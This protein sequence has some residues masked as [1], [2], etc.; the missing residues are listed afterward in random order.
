MF[1]VPFGTREKTERRRFPYVNVGIVLVCIGV[2]IWQ[3]YVAATGGE[4]AL[5]SFITTF[6]A[7]PQT[8]TDGTPLEVGLFTSMF[9]H[10]SIVHLLGNMIYLLP[11]GDNVE[12]RLGHVRYLLF[13]ILCGLVATLGFVLLNPHS[14][15]PLLGASGAIAGVLGGYIVS[16]PGA[17][18]RGI[19]FLIII[20]FRVDLPALIFIGYWFFMQLFSTLASYG[21]NPTE[22]GGVAFAA[23]VVGFITGMILM[24]LFV[25]TTR[26]QN[27]VTTEDT[28]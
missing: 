13:Y 12:D 18:V 28:I 5:A 7:I 8:V 22:T 6:A 1:F 21:G 10:A 9:L 4:S 19:F 17:W 27:S 15:V 11:F 14:N 20:P 26:R 2:F 25:L 23:H 16:Q 24:P 3:T